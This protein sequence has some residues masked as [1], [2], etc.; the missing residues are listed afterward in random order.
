MDYIYNWLKQNRDE[1]Y[2]QF[3]SRLIPT[4]DTATIIGVRTPILRK[5]AK[6][7]KTTETAGEFLHELPHAYFEENQ[8]HGFII[9]ALV[10]IVALGVEIAMG[11]V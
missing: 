1:E 10:V 3:Q 11:I 4:V 2:G 7:L 5:M 9:S 8:L 6:E